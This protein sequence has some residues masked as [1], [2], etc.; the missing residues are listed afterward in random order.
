MLYILALVGFGGG[1]GGLIADGRRHGAYRRAF[2]AFRLPC[3]LLI[4][5]TASARS[6]KKDELC[7]V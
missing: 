3:R 5:R 4:D 6:S 1:M 7:K 2:S